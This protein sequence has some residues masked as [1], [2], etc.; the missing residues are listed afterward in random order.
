MRA[1]DINAVAEASV[2][3]P[4][5]RSSVKDALA[6]NVSGSSPRFVPVARGRYALAGR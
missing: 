5:A 2:G 4:V 6:S 3:E 1:K